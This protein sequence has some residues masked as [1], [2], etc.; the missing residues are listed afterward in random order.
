MLYLSSN[1]TLQAGILAKTTQDASTKAGNYKAHTC[2]NVNTS[3]VA[4][5]PGSG[6]DMGKGLKTGIALPCQWLESQ[7]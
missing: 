2:F 3:L 5:P 4:F 1:K 7:A 6:L